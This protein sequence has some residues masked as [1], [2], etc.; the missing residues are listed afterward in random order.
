MTFVKGATKGKVWIEI[1]KSDFQNASKE[2]FICIQSFD[3]QIFFRVPKTILL[4]AVM[5]TTLTWTGNLT[6]IS[7]LSNVFNQLVTKLLQGLPRLGQDC[8]WRR[9]RQQPS[10]EGIFLKIFSETAKNKTQE[11][12]LEHRIQPETESMIKIILE[13]PFVVSHLLL[14]LVIFPNIIFWGGSL[15]FRQIFHLGSCLPEKYRNAESTYV[16]GF[17]PFP[18]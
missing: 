10:D 18:Q 2:K 14:W 6:K 5:P 9:H 8:L 11:A 13:T 17:R 1:M 15:V 12:K 4:G 7:L 16:L 3:H